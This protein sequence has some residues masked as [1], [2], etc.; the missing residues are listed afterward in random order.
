M[1]FSVSKSIWLLLALLTAVPS[2]FALDDT[3]MTTG[4]VPSQGGVKQVTIVEG[5]ERPW[6][7][8][9]LPSG[10]MLITERPGR[11]RIVRNG[12]LLPE[13]VEGVPAVF[14]EGQGGFLDVAL[15][16]SFASNQTV[17]FTYAHGTSRENR[18]RLARAVLNNDRIGGWQVIFEV[19]TPKRGTQHFGSRLL[20][21]PDG[22]L[23]VSVGDG[24]NP[25]VRLDGE[26][27]RESAQR[28]DRHLGKILRLNDDGT[29]PS[30]NPFVGSQNAEKVVWSYG[31]RNIQGLAFDPIRNR[32]WASE[33]G[34]L[35]G[36]ELNGPEAGKNYGWPA[37][38]FSR[39]YFNGAKISKHTTMSGMEDPILV[40]MTA[41]APSGLAAYTG[42]RYGGWQGNL[43]AGGLVSQDV[44]RLV[45]DEN[46][47]VV[48]QHAIRIGERVRDVRQ[49]PDGYLYV[50]TDETSGR[51]IR[52]EPAPGE[53]GGGAP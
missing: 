36:D 51:L 18:T 5:L 11:L 47:R 17:Y 10:D 3:Y 50:L 45:M 26:L 44:R 15:H 9:W 24:G 35:G 30:D 6:S 23:L 16:P 22:T 2:V 52:L 32:I 29:V 28:L 46:G 12:R 1:R 21:L 43:F 53:D 7:M 37:V 27:I 8:A 20:W 39:E 41:I 42:D 31:H 49:G 38:T 13:A 34:A 25:P 4:N 48:S 19:S 40:W 14:A 33:H